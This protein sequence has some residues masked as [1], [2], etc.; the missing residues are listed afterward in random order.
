MTELSCMT[1]QIVEYQN[2]HLLRVTFERDTVPEM[3]NVL[4]EFE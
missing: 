2:P 3:L 1:Q 4:D